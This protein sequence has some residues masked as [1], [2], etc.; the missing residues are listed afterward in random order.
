MQ[1][2]ELAAEKHVRPVSF[3]YHKVIGNTRNC[4]QDI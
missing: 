2:T 4:R 1:G 3:S